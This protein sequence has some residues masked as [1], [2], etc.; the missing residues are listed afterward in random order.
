MISQLQGFCNS[1]EF[2]RCETII[3]SEGK[4][5]LMSPSLIV[6]SIIEMEGIIT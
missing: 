3:R 6:D 4:L 2:E 5:D 1:N